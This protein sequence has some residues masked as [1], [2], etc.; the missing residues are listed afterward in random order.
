MTSTQP[1]LIDFTIPQN[2]DEIQTLC[3]LWER[4]AG[5]GYLSLQLQLE[6]RTKKKRAQN[7]RTCV[8]DSSVYPHLATLWSSS[9][10]PFVRTCTYV[11]L[12][13]LNLLGWSIADESKV[14]VNMRRFP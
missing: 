5:R 4:G 3:K 12:H 13:S 7:P 11:H 6:M 10:Q 9:Y 14:K 1:I 8:F 2:W